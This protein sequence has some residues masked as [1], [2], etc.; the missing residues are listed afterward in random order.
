MSE[1]TEGGLRGPESD[2]QALSILMRD[3]LRAFAADAGTGVDSG[4]G[5][6]RCDLWVKFGGKDVHVQL[7]EKDGQAANL[8]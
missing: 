1:L 7:T 3:W 4:L 2:V 5:M 6:G 8:K